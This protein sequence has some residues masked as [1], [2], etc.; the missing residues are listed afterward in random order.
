MSEKETL[1]K[2]IQAR[3]GHR[4]VVRKN[5]AKARELLPPRGQNL[6][7]EQQSKLESIKQ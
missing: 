5:V 3:N 6:P 7:P 2:K 4:L 1:K